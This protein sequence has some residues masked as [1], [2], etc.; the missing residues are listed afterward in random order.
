MKPHEIIKEINDLKDK[1]KVLEHTLKAQQTTLLQ[2]N[3]K[4]N[5]L[6]C[7]R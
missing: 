7:N 2:H 1:V 4:I 3:N 6:W 5:E